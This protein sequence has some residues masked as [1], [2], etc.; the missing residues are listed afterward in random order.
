MRSFCSLLR[1]TVPRGDDN[2]N[3]V[4]S[5]GSVMVNEVTDP[6]NTPTA[7]GLVTA[8]NT[9]SR[10]SKAPPRTQLRQIGESSVIFKG[11]FSFAMS[12]TLKPTPD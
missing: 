8:G 7:T 3:T 1:V 4:A 6:A 12:V 5:V 10:H 9:D 2:A 11:N